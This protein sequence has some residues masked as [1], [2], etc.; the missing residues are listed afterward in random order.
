VNVAEVAMSRV[1]LNFRWFLI[2]LTAK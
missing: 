2:G 1:E